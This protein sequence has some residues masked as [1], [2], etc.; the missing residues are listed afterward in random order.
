MGE[1]RLGLGTPIWRDDFPSKDVTLD[2]D[3]IGTG[4]TPKLKKITYRPTLKYC[5]AIYEYRGATIDVR[6]DYRMDVVE[7]SVKDSACPMIR[8][9]YSITKSSDGDPENVPLI[10]FEYFVFEPKDV[11]DITRCLEN[12]GKICG[13]LYPMAEKL[14][15]FAKD[16]GSILTLKG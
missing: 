3:N 11:P 1:A 8:V 13:W 7:F 6:Y 14:Y 2:L 15:G 10:A 16:P 4:D 12:I 5:R 9:S